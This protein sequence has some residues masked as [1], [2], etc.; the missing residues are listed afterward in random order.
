VQKELQRRAA[1]YVEKFLEKRG[2]QVT[3]GDKGGATYLTFFTGDY[4][5]KRTVAIQVKNALDL[6]YVISIQTLD[7]EG[8]IDEAEYR[9]ISTMETQFPLFDHLLAEL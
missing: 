1:D 7:E 3:R 5:T 9:T 2:R 4:D 8:T 6:S